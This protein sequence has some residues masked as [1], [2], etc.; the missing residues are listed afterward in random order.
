MK[1]V[2]L[3]SDVHA[4]PLAL[5]A[6]WADA[7]A[8]GVERFICLG[9]IVDIGPEPSATVAQ[10]KERCEGVIGGNHDALDEAPTLPFLADIERWTREQLAPADMAWLEALPG[11]LRVDLEGHDL[12]CV[13]GSPVSDT[14]EINAATDEAT[15]ARWLDEHPCEL[16]VAGHTHVQL[17]RRVGHRTVVNVG[18][19]GMPFASPAAAGPPVVMPWAEYAIISS[20]GA[21][22]SIS[23]DLRRVAY[24]HAAFAKRTLASGM[25]HAE[26]FLSH[27]RNH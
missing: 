19:V 11:T 27:F 17:L 8:Q 14:E 26:A 22:S 13:H 16:L 1:R 6:V 20:R 23:V 18:S 5:E 4:N 21:A 15:L 24:D 9:D 25:P 7:V 10:V 3:L 12:L 2:A